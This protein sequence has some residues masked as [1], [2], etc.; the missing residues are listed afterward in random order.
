MIELVDR[1]PPA[2]LMKELHRSVPNVR[3][4]WDR[5][6]GL[7]MIE[8]RGR[9]SGQWHYVCY[10]A[11]FVGQYQVPVYRELPTSAGPILEKLHDIDMARFLRNPKAAWKELERNMDEARVQRARTKMEK[12]RDAMRQYGEDLAARGGGIRQTFG[13]GKS[14]G[15]NYGRNRLWLPRGSDVTRKFASDMQR[16]Q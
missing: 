5:P 9:L 3:I 4:R 13:F 1:T 2:D 16:E 12:W 11:D 15:L 14:A 10:W 6:R 7:W 8:E